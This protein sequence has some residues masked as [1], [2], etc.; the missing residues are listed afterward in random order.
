MM[1]V[2]LYLVHMLSFLLLID[3]Y[4]FVLTCD[5]LSHMRSYFV[6]TRA[7]GCNW[8]LDGFFKE[9]KCS[10]LKEDKLAIIVVKNIAYHK[11]R[12]NRSNSG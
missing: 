7:I 1:I 9:E 2:T 3:V 10:R 4:E 12:C 6:T 5:L 11:I 8:F